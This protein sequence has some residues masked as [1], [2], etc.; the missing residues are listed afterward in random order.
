MGSGVHKPRAQVGHPTVSSRPVSESESERQ[1]AR[2]GASEI[3]PASERQYTRTSRSERNLEWDVIFHFIVLYNG[4]TMSLA[5]TEQMGLVLRDNPCIVR[6]RVKS[7]KTSKNSLRLGL[8]PRL[9]RASFPPDPLVGGLGIGYKLSTLFPLSPHVQ[10]P[11][12]KKE[13]SFLD[14]HASAINSDS[15]KSILHK[16]R[17]YFV[18]NCNKHNNK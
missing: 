14:C 16:I 5:S 3:F 4:V 6:T 1:R 10:C 17:G 8:H 7:H 13:N 2:N 9:H 12:P 15:T 18:E 11:V